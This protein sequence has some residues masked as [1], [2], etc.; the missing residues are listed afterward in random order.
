[1]AEAATVVFIGEELETAGTATS[2]SVQ[3]TVHR[4]RVDTVLKGELANGTE[5]EVA[6]V[7]DGC[8]G[9]GSFYP[10]G[11]PLDVEGEAQ[12]FL[13]GVSDEWTSLTPFA[14]AMEVPASGE[15]PWQP[16]EP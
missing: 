5:I 11:D 14:G 10:E 3:A 2:M 16:A 1:M 6:S 8:S 12:F 15:L 7:P 4:I 9:T 13:S